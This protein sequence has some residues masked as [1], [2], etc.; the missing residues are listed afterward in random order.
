VDVRVIAATNKSLE[1]E[2][3]VGNFRRD[4]YYRLNVIPIVV[5]SLRERREDIPE[6]VEEFVA[7]VVA[8]TGVRPKRFTEEALR[9]MLAYPWPG[10][11]RELRNVVERLVIMVPETEI[12]PEHLGFLAA[13]SAEEDTVIGFKTDGE[14]PPLREARARFEAAYIERVLEQCEGNVSQA[15][16]LLGIERSHLHRKIRQLGITLR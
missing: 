11:V 4:L 1:E 2:I 6:L 14:L 3:G 10:N 9:R 12:R 15:A 16:R 5:P 7:E 8:E 13:G